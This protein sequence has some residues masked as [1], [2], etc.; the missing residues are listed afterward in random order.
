[1]TDFMRWF[2]AHYIRPQ[3]ERV[4]RGAYQYWL[5]ALENDLAPHQKEDYE[6]ALEFCAVH[7]FL[8]GVETGRGLSEALGPTRPA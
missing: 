3:L 1:M 2:Y 6:K 8:L 7:A 5:S 4:P